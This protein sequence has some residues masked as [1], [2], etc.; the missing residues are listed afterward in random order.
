MMASALDNKQDPEA[1][2][3]YW[4]KATEQDPDDDDLAFSFADG[5][6]DESSTMA[7]EHGV[8]PSCGV[9]REATS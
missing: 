9:P 1:A 6:S 5:L 4:Q 3:P 7:I 8:L 2:L